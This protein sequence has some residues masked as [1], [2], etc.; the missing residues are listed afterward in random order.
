M[1]RTI[2]Y[3][4]FPS[5]ISKVNYFTK[6]W[7]HNNLISRLEDYMAKVRVENCDL[8]NNQ[9]SFICPD[10]D[11][12]DKD[13]YARLYWKIG[14]NPISKNLNKF[15]DYMEGKAIQVYTIKYLINL[16]TQTKKSLA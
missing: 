8:S 15:G 13:N 1:Q 16:E 10:F 3:P 4:P 12:I 2:K 14:G 9:I 5:S 6:L 7:L 11:T